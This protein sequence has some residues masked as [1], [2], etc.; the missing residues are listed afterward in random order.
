MGDNPQTDMWTCR[1]YLSLRYDISRVPVLST[2]E[3][4]AYVLD[5]LPGGGGK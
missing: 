1:D 5:R 4:L 3:H 2:E